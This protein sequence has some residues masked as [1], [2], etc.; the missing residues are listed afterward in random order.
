MTELPK[1]FPEYVIMYKTLT[2]KIH[3]LES[4][5]KVNLEES[6]DIQKRIT[7]IEGQREKIRNMFPEKFFDSLDN[8]NE[9]D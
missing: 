9:I 2:K 5:K 1:K 8:K 7:E 6:R 4:K 3:Q